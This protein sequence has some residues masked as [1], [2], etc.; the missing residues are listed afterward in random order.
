MIVGRVLL[1]GEL[2]CNAVVDDTLYFKRS[3]RI[4]VFSQGDPNA[5]Y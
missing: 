4:I 3:K 5:S 2:S 1:S